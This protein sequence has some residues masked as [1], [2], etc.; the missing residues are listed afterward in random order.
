MIKE[1]YYFGSFNPFHEGHKM[2]ALCVSDHFYKC[3]V[4]ITPS[5]CSPF[6]KKKDM[7]PVETRIELIKAALDGCGIL[8]TSNLD[9]STIDVEVGGQKETHYTYETLEVIKERYNGN[10]KE[11]GFL[12]GSDTLAIFDKWKNWEWIMDNFTVIVYPRVG[13]NID[14]LLQKF[15]KAVL[16]TAYHSME[17]PPKFGDED[18]KTNLTKEQVEKLKEIKFENIPVACTSA[19]PY[20]LFEYSSTQIR[21]LLENFEENYKDLSLMYNDKCLKIL[22]KIYNK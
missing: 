12:I 17:F 3:K 14:Y 11:I 18:K 9:V 10:S 13:D 15:P 4:H 8:D 5:P 21:A 16:G 7:L 19:Q 1:I 2:V 20:V 22:E 6:K